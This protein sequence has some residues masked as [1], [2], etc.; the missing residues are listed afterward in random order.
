M[1]NQSKIIENS[2]LTNPKTA[3]L[4]N[5]S[6]SEFSQH[7][8]ISQLLQPC[9]R[10]IDKRSSDFAKTGKFYNLFK[11]VK[12]GN[13]TPRKAVKQYKRTTKEKQDTRNKI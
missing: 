9:K 4:Q 8:N 7:K 5:F 6:E 11:L 2:T 12:W 13:Q 10:I 3:G 1:K